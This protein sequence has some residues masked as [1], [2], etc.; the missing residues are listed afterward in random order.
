MELDGKNAWMVCGQ[1][2]SWE[3]QKQDL[4]APVA[5]PGGPGEAL[6]PL[7]LAAASPQEAQGPWGKGGF[8]LLLNTCK[9]QR[10]LLLC[11]VTPADS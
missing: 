9:Q 11:S 2:E 7:Q 4:A 1:G 8:V 10:E 5:A 3:D 6:F